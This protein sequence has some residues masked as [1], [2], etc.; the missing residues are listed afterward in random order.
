MARK[1][2]KARSLPLRGSIR[3]GR[4]D[5]NARPSRR[6]RA[7]KTDVEHE[8]LRAREKGGE[9]SAIAECGGDRPAVEEPK[10]GASRRLSYRAETAEAH[11]GSIKAQKHRRRLRH[12]AEETRSISRTEETFDT[13]GGNGAGERTAKPG[14]QTAGDPAGRGRAAQVES[15]NARK[16]RQRKQ[17]GSF[18]QAEKD[19][20]AAA[21]SFEK[22]TDT[23]IKR[24]SEIAS[25][26]KRA[27]LNHSD[28][29]SAMAH[30]AGRLARKTASMM[31]AAAMQAAKRRRSEAEEDN[32]AVEALSL[33]HISPM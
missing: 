33:I 8:R 18:R 20:S 10:A 1:V 2:Y 17:A 16:Q 30:G 27:R 9:D 4:A 15:G 5:E 32:A 25:F 3:G 14:R 7:G 21:E 11:T 23:E 26:Q 24:T 6:R 22:I 28:E 13:F 19:A 29:E 31:G 12:S